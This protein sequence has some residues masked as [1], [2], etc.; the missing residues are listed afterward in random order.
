MD[1]DLRIA[2]PHGEILEQASERP[3]KLVTE[4]TRPRALTIA[5]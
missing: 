5:R 3:S 2:A 1:R 4:R